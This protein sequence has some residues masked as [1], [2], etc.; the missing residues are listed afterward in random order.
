VL[1]NG[2]SEIAQPKIDLVSNVVADSPHKVFLG[3]ISSSLTSDKVKEIVTAFGQLKAYHWKVDTRIRPPQSFAFLEYLD[4]M[5][6]LRAC[7]GLNGMRLGS[8]IL[9]VVQ[10]TPDASLEVG[11]FLT[12]DQEILPVYTTNLF[13]LC[14]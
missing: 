8:T 3:G 2:G 13:N 7:A 9:T 10:A 5:V 11:F 6:T 1:Q 14:L 4:P 12:H